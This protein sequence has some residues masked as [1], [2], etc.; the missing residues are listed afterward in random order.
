MKNI[1][2]KIIGY[3]APKKVNNYVFENRF[4]DYY[5]DNDYANFYPIDDAYIQE[6]DI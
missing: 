5:D 6:E 2:H 3:Y 1:R 4:E